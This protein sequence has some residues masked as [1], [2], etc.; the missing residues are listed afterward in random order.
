M[1]RRIAALS[2]DVGELR[3]GSTRKVK[4]RGKRVKGTQRGALAT[5]NPMKL[6]ELTGVKP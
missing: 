2:C 4:E 5:R 3:S 6:Y 1:R